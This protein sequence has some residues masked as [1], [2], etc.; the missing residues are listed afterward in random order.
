MQDSVRI[1]RLRGK[2]LIEDKGF[3][4]IKV[5]KAAYKPLKLTLRGLLNKTCSTVL[6]LAFGSG[7]GITLI[8]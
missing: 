8:I 4:L 6:N 5:N 2:A 1:K 7:M 3:S